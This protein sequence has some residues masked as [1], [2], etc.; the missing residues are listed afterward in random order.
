MEDHPPIVTPYDDPFFHPDWRYRLATLLAADPRAKY[1]SPDAVRD[2]VVRTT[3]RH[4]K[5]A[6][7]K[8]SPDR[9]R[10]DRVRRWAPTGASER[11][12]HVIAALL[13]TEAPMDALAID[14]GC[15]LE[16]LQAYERL[17]FNVRDPAGNMALSPAQRAFFATEGTFKPTAARPDYLMWRRVAVNAGYQALIQILELGKGSWAEAPKVDLAEVTVAMAKGE[18]LARL[19]TG[20]LSTGEL[21][22]LESNRIRDRLARHMTGELKMKDEG[23]ELA[24][25]IMQLVAPKMV[26]LDRIR[27]AQAADAMST[28]HQAQDAIGQ[29]D[30][31]DN[32]PE[33]GYDA[34]DRMLR[35]VKDQFAKMAAKKATPACTAA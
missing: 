3:A 20:G 23:M 19:A 24:I 17:H 7:T 5:A 22:R 14:V 35:P 21:A 9:N 1:P 15:A 2:V 33:A 8:P 29:T 30:I 32:G 10:L 11:V 13:L 27:Q 26:D 28:L 16:D 25:Q 4:L 34:M 18:T 6:Q 31:P 12:G